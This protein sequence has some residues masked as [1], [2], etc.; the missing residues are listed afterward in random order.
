MGLLNHRLYDD[1]KFSDENVKMS[2]KKNVELP[3][4]VLL[5]SGV[6]ITVTLFRN[7]IISSI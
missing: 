5:I 2:V 4:V 7:V 6:E 3:L 1:E